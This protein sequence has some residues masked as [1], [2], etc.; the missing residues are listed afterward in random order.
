MDARTLLT[1]EDLAYCVA[2]RRRIHRHPELGFDLPRTQALVGQEL[3]KLGLTWTD[4]YAPCSV[5]SYINPGHPGKTV[6]IRADMDALP[7]TEKSGEPFTSEEPGKMHACGHDAHTAILLTVARVLCRVREQ[8]P[9]RVMVLFQPSE[10]C[11]ESGARCM[12][13]NGVTEG[14]DCALMLH[15]DNSCPA[16]F[17]GVTEKNYAAACDPIQIT[18]HGRTAHATKYWEGVDAIQMGMEIW[19]A[20]SRMVTEVAGDREHI[21]RLGVFQGGTAHNVVSDLC[22]LEITFRYYDTSLGEAV[23]KKGRTIIQDICARFGGTADIRWETSAP[24]VVN[25]TALAHKYDASAKKVAGA[26]SGFVSG[27]MG[28]EDFAWYLTKI[29]GVA[30]TL[31]TGNVRKGITAVGHTNH[32]RIDESAFKNGILGFV[33]FILDQ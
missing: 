17:L 14:V 7:I 18:L 4:R 3:E 25:D 22:T 31:G 2:I 1:E 33:Q 26:L 32:Y 13:E 20:L 9:C 6:L 12:V 21:F 27:G 11:A 8:L 19:N 24:P 10:E 5:V 28:S 15:C 16:G 30:T 23:Q 29:P